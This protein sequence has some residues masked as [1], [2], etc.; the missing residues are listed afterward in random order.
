MNWIFGILAITLLINTIA[1]IITVFHRHR[2]IPT[3]LAWLLVLILLPVIGFIIFAFFGRGIAQENLFAISNEEHIGLDRLKQMAKNSNNRL[4]TATETTQIAAKQIT[5]FDRSEDAPITVHNS[6]RIFTDGKEKFQALFQDIQNAQETI[7]LEYYSFINDPLGKQ[8]VDLL[9][10]KATAGVEVRVIYDRWGSPGA[11]AKFFQP[12][13]AAGGQVMPFITSQ[14]A[15]T[16][17]RL[18]YHLH[19]KI[20]VIDGQVGWTGGF[21]IGEQYIGNKP[22]FGYWRDTHV[23]I[24]GF[25]ALSLQERFLLD[26][27]ASVDK[28]HSKIYFQEKY[29]PHTLAQPTDIIPI[30]IVSDGPDSNF[31]TLKGGFMDFILNAKR[32]VLIQTPYLIPDDAMIDALL[33]A[34]RAGIKIKIMIPQMPDHPFIY[35]ATQFYANLFTK[36]NIEVYI[37]KNGFMHAK[38][39]VFDNEVSAIGSMNQ[40]Y[41]SYSL[42]FEADA[43]FYDKK[44]SQ[45][46]TDIFQNDMTNSVLLTQ[47]M[48]DQQSL[49]LKFKQLFSRLLSPIL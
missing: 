7:H 21:N 41:R 5:Y 40:D 42:N 19:R 43:F 34:A 9:A 29:F 26:W 44:V 25:A 37:Y 17:N 48:I 14:N 31:D 32:S 6:T 1:A 23:R 38:T 10:S 11:N 24:Y 30:Q 47:Q 36:H 3:T 4:Y 49:W 22:K 20:V 28:H 33:V 16:K 2:S 13:T 12:L 46:L 27:N 8:V 18:N 39:A 35:R 15:V 45:Q